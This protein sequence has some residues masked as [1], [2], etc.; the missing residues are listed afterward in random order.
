MRP[1]SRDLI[2]RYISCRSSR[3]HEIRACQP[4]EPVGLKS[5]GCSTDRVH[6]KTVS[7]V[8]SNVAGKKGV[9]DQ[10]TPGGNFPIALQLIGAVQVFVMRADKSYVLGAIKLNAKSGRLDG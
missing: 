5:D 6:N 3:N 9:R 2:A 1:S 7:I 10:Y 8:A 4:I